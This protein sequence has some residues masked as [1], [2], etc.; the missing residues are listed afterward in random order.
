MRF[1]LT[2]LLIT[3]F[4]TTNFSKAIGQ[5]SD[6]PEWIKDLI[7]YEIAT[8]NFTS[9]Q[10]AGSGT[11]LSAKEKVPYLADLGITGVWLS[12]HNWADSSH[13][14]GIWTQY[15]TMRP[16]SI[17]ASLGSKKDLKELI[18]EFHKHDIKV[19]LDI[20]THGVMSNSPLIEEH[21]EWFKGGS[22]GMTD[23]DWAGNHKDLDEWWIK[24]HV[25]Y[26]LEL[27][28]DGYRLDVD[29]YRPDL[30]KEIKTRCSKGA[31]PIAVFLEWY[32][33]GDNVTDFLQHNLWLKV[34]FT[35][36][37]TVRNII[38]NVAQAFEDAYRGT[39]NYTVYL[40]YSDDSTRSGSSLSGGDLRVEVKNQPERQF[41]ADSS[42]Q[43]ADSN[44]IKLSIGNIDPSK[45]VQR[46]QVISDPWTPSL[47]WEIGAKEQTAGVVMGEKT[48]LSLKPYIPQSGFYSLQLSCHDAGWEGFPENENPYVAEGSRSLM[49]YN[50]LLTPAIPIFFGGEEFDASYVP[51]PRLTPDLYGKGEP[52]TGRWLYGAIVGW[53]QL[54]KKKHS[55]ML[56]D[57]KKLIAIR[58]AEKDLLRSYRYD[59]IPDI[60]ELEYSASHSVPKPYAIQNQDKIII[61]AGNFLEETVACTIK[62]PLQ[63]TNLLPDKKYKVEDLWNGKTFRLTGKEVAEFAFKIK[64]DRSPKGGLAVFKITK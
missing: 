63:K 21:P 52:G 3:T 30:W 6:E 59:S 7:I 20:I 25:D 5:A 51:N 61:V 53:D 36:Q 1:I 24:T 32:R 56:E 58:K 18:D 57:T 10:G 38:S 16:D 11:F 54:D 4:L 23:Y 8:K 29:I 50:C 44:N 17:D 60:F 9:P 40:S 35:A 15:A 48:E 34:P 62:L 37:D 28:V 33:P 46:I 39:F 49:G 26:A 14:Y 2:L 45:Y 31:H 27:G 41:L 42:S 13:F 12:G 43:L 19:F 47:Q 64:A 55:A 22:W